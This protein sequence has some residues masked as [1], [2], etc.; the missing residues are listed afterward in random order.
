MSQEE[1]VPIAHLTRTFWPLSYGQ[2]FGMTAG[3]IR[4]LFWPLAIVSGWLAILMLGAAWH[5]GRK[6]RA[7]LKAPLTE[8]VEHLT[9]IW[10][11]RVTRWRILGL[12]MSVLSILNLVSWLVSEALR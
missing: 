11:R 8:E 3:S 10:E 6:F 1:P 4:D 5:A 7:L 2:E 12:A 9:H